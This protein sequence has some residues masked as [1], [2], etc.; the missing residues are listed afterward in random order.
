[1]SEPALQPREKQRNLPILSSPQGLQQGWNATPCNKLLFA[2][3]KKSCMHKI[4]LLY[5]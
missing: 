3:S 2:P 1:M 5:P 4:I